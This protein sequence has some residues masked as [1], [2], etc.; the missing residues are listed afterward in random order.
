M[1]PRSFFQRLR[2]DASGTM[3]VETAI[4]APVLVLMS[5]GAYQVSGM[6]ARQSELQSAAA[7]ASAI[8]LAAKPDTDAKLAT[9]K[10]VVMASTGLTTDKVTIE[11]RVRCGTSANYQTSID[12]CGTSRP[13]RYVKIYLSDTY[14]PAWTEF[15]VGSPLSYNVTRY[16]MISQDGD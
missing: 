11:A 12:S 6:V 14:R 4:I 7:E 5:L 8:A 16:V 15:G 3:I 2:R 13:S 9:V 10:Q 1:L